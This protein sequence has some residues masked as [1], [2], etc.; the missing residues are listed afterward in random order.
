M[1]KNKANGN[2]VPSPPP[3][4]IIENDNDIIMY[5]INK[6]NLLIRSSP[7]RVGNFLIQLIEKFE[8]YV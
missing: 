4:T 6:I 1:K 7:D 8:S 5:D 3:A 2:K